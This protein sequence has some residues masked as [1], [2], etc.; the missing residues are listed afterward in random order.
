MTEAVH[1]LSH[2]FA[3]FKGGIGTY[4]EETCRAFSAC[5]KSVTL[6]APDYGR[7]ESEIWPFTVKRVPMRGEQDW[8]WRFRLA[9]VL[10]KSFARE[11]P[12]HVVL[13]EPGPIR[14]W[15][16]AGLLGLPRP[17]QLSIILHGSELLMLSRLAHRRRLL[18]GLLERADRIGVVSDEI[19]RLLKRTYP[20]LSRPVVRVPGAVRSGWEADPVPEKET[21]S[22]L[23]ILQ[24][25]RVHPRKGQDVLMEALR[26]LPEPIQQRVRV[27]LIGPAGRSAYAARVREQIRAHR[28]PVEWVGACSES[29]LRE[30]YRRAHLFV[31]PSVPYKTSVEGLGIGL[32]EAAHYGCAVI[33]SRIGG[34]PEALRENETGFLV[35]PGDS[36]SLA[37][38][39]HRFIEAPAEATE[40]GRSGARFVRAGFSWHTNVKRLGA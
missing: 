39:L 29:R 14:T 15:M 38:V 23:E 12:G 35:P 11:L 36:R 37:A 40:M 2:E 17:Q 33:G 28:L 4:V 31:M 20:L 22:H 30:A 3:P 7:E 34:I 26:H 24:V 5:G 8:L 13:A 1:V 25:G 10:R 32:L 16:Y 21:G 9:R 18:G 6:W 19:H 27:R